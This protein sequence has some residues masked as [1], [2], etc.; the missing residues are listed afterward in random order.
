MR[1]TVLIGIGLVIGSA[2]GAADLSAIKQRGYLTVAEP[3][4]AA[5]FSAGAGGQEA[6]FDTAL[7]A[8]LARA[9]GLEIRKVATSP[10]GLIAAVIEGRADL[11]VG[12][13]EIA[14]DRENLVTFTRPLADAT[15]TYLIRH[16]DARI[17]GIGDLDGRPFGIVGGTVAIAQLAQLEF[18]LAQA[19]GRLGPSSEF[20]ATADGLDA[21]AGGRIDYLI[22]PTAVADAL[23]AAEP[24]KLTRGEA[25]SSAA[26]FAWAVSSNGSEL[27]ALLD[28][29][30]DAEATNGALAKAQTTAFG[31]AYPDLPTRWDGHDWWYARKDRPIHFPVPGNGEPD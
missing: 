19:G 9:E 26:Y 24:D 22:A 21:L 27:G 10:A 7:L 31:H 14:R 30:F 28:K 29:F 3:E 23:V 18:R 16:D 15:A 11:A 17:H 20:K 2:A 1:K 8:D 13:I 25:L 4:N 5:P 12:G 6:G